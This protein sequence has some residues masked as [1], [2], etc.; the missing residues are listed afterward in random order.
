MRFIAIAYSS[1]SSARPMAIARRGAIVSSSACDSFV[2]FSVTRWIGVAERDRQVQGLDEVFRHVARQRALAGDE[3]TGD[4]PVG[5][6]RVVVVDR[7]ADLVG[8]RLARRVERL[9]D[10]GDGLGLEVG[11]ALVGAA[12]EADLQTQGVG[13]VVTDAAVA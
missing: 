4:L 2:L 5:L 6:L 12:G 3:E 7:A 10:L 13:L 11:D 1:S 8:E 9:V